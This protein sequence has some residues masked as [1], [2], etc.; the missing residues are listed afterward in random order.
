LKNII[1]KSVSR[2]KFLVFITRK[3]ICFN[4]REILLCYRQF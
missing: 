3:T 1:K 2:W 4:G